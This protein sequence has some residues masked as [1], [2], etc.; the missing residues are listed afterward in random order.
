MLVDRVARFLLIGLAG[1][2]AA[3][4]IFGGLVV[5]PGMPLESGRLAVFGLHH[6]RRCPCWNR[7]RRRFGRGRV[8]CAET[9]VGPR[10]VCRGW[11]RDDA[12]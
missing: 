4:A 9:N 2:L 10:R 1:F 8:A 6:S 7:G 11:R 5:V 12:V 3:T